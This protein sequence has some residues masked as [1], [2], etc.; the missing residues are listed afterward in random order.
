MDDSRTGI[1]AERQDA[2]CGSLGI[3]QEC[4]CHIAVVVRSLGI[5]E[6]GSYLLVVFTT[7]AELHIVEGLLSQQG[8]SLGCNLQD[9]LALKC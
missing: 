3:A 6:D 4:Q 9:L 2:F 8:Q 5:A 1:L 7:Q